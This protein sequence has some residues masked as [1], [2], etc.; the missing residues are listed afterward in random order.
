MNEL[1]WIIFPKRI[2]S[3]LEM[4]QRDLDEFMPR[5]NKERTHQGRRCQGK[6]PTVTFLEGKKLLEEKNLNEGVS[7]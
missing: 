3:H 4:L 2:C 5:V 6:T 7:T 1:Y